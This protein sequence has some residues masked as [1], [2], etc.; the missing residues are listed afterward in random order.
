MSHNPIAGSYTDPDTCCE[1]W[2]KVVEVASD[3]RYS[4]EF[5]GILVRSI[6]S[7]ESAVS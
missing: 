4:N 5:L 3:H 6:L 1:D 7:A 2:Q